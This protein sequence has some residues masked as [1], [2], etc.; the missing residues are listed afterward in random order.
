M[1]RRAARLES[2]RQ[3]AREPRADRRVASHTLPDGRGGDGHP[4]EHA[5]TAALPGAPSRRASDHARRGWQ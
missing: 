4:A 1:T 2:D 5:L 3:A